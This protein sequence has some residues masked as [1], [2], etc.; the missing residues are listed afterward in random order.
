VSEERPRTPSLGWD[1]VTPY[2]RGFREFAEG[3]EAFGFEQIHA[4]ALPFLP[5]TPGLMLDVGAGSGRDAAWFAA[6]GWEV[7]AVE[8]AAALRAEAGRLHPSPQIRWVDDRLPALAA[9]H[10]LGLGFDLVWLS[11]VWQHMPPEER[12]RAMRKLATLLKPGGRMVLT[13][14]HGPAP[15]D[16]PMWP[17]DAHEVER[18]GLDHG[19]A[20]RVDHPNTIEHLRFTASVLFVSRLAALRQRQRLLPG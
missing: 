7:V 14:R 20:L 2:H 19:L 1:T 11:G 12:P 16:R 5:A 8:P 18:L 13:L 6:R 17:V 15:A 4:G 10:R 3:Y 9:L